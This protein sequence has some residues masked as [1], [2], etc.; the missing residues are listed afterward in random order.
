ML[1]IKYIAK[2]NSK[3]YRHLIHIKILFLNGKINFELKSSIIKGPD[4]K[5]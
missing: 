1:T 5:T 4:S 3:I 2:N